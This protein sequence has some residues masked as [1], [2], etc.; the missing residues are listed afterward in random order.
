MDALDAKHLPVLLRMT[1][2]VLGTRALLFVC[3]A[4]AFG[5]FCWS[6]W[7]GTSVSVI[8]AACFTVSVLWPILFRFSRQESSHDETS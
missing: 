6:M 7:T 4:M 2:T 3:V 5:L 8:T 1:Y